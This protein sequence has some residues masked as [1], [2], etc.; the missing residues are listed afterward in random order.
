MTVHEIC[1][2]A[3]ATGCACG[4]APGK[5]C[6]CQPAAPGGV[7]LARI[8]H[9]RRAG[10][11]EAADF[12]AVIHDADVFTGYTIILDPERTAA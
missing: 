7:H 1:Q 9:A 8:A 3:E 10:L 12:A 6:D 2:Q 11:I 5:P 4:A